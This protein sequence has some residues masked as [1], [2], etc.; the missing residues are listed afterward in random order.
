MASTVATVL[1]PYSKG[2]RG[3]VHSRKKRKDTWK[4]KALMSTRKVTARN[5]EKIKDAMTAWIKQRG[6]KAY[7]V[8]TSKGYLVIWLGTP[9]KGGLQAGYRIR[10]YGPR[11]AK[12]KAVGYPLK[13]GT[14]KAKKKLPGGGG[15]K[16]TAK[17]K[18]AK[19]KTAKK[20]KGISL[21]T[22]VKLAKA[23]VNAGKNRT[24]KAAQRAVGKMAKAG[25]TVTQIR[26]AKK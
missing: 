9:P 14:K 22:Q 18:T 17:K 2:K 21:A 23:R 19:K 8:T 1:N 12:F 10:E 4:W 7:K 24:F 13:P 3:K 26:N 11:G 20:G 5:R 16:K 6:L 25:K 15:R